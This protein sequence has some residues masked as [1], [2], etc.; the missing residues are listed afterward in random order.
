M[1]KMTS[2][3]AGTAQLTEEP[4]S[5]IRRREE[6][7]LKTSAENGERGAS[8]DVRWKTVPQTSGCDRKVSVAD[9]GQSSTSNVHIG[10]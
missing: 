3:F 9:S 4:E 7:R 6:I 10:S 5:G 8:S 2:H 1:S